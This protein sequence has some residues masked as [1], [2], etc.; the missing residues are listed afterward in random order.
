[1]NWSHSNKLVRHNVDIGVSY[2]SDI[3][4]VIA[5]LEEASLQ[6]DRVLKRPKPVAQLISFGDS[7]VNF[8]VQ[9]WINDP[10]RGLLNVKSDLLIAIW[11]ILKINNVEIPFPQTDLHIK[12]ITH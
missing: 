1:M 10:Q 5:L 12:S 3:H 2:N 7:S 9:F 8:K 6:V 4:Q 11:D